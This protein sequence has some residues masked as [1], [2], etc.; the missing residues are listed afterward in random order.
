M[1]VPNHAVKMKDFARYAAA[2]AARALARRTGGCTF[3]RCYLLT[4][5]EFEGVVHFRKNSATPLS[6]GWTGVSGTGRGCFF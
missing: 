1:L 6:G 4:R 5:S 3:R 2:N